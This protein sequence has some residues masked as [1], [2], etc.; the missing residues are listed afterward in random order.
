MKRLSQYKVEGKLDE[1]SSEKDNDKHVMDLH[2]TIEGQ[3]AALNSRMS[4][5]A[6]YSEQ[7]LLHMISPDNQPT[8]SEGYS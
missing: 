7:T 4:M 2:K 1:S 8:G 5:T 6:K 3:L